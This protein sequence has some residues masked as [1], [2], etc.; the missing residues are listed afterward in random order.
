MCDDEHGTSRRCLAGAARDPAVPPFIVRTDA[1]RRQFLVE[2]C[3]MR[4]PAMSLPRRIVAP[5]FD[6]DEVPGAAVLLKHVGAR[7]AVV[8]PGGISVARQ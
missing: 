1:Q 5:L 8:P 3:R 2:L 7:V 6:N 4:K